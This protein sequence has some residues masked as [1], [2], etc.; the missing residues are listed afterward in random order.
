MELQHCLAA[1]EGLGCAV[2]CVLSE[3]EQGWFLFREHSG[4]LEQP[5]L[6]ETSHLYLFKLASRAGH[7]PLTCVLLL[8]VGCARAVSGSLCEPLGWF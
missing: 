5:V 7:L 4:I 8:K 2:L 6:P 3:A 1:C